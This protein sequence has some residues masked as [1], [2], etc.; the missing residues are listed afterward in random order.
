[1]EGIGRIP[2]STKTIILKSVF[3]G[4]VEENHYSL[5]D[6]LVCKRYLIKEKVEE[7]NNLSDINNIDFEEEIDGMVYFDD[8]EPKF[9]EGKYSFNRTTVF[10]KYS[11]TRIVYN[12][13]DH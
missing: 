9:Y 13:N 2:R 7:I 3:D 4:T 5:L 8:L 11:V 6:I 10:V 1:M 12:E